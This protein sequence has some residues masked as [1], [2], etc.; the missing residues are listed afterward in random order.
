MWPPCP[1]QGAHRSALPSRNASRRGE[2]E[3]ERAARLTPVCI[4]QGYDYCLNILY[5]HIAMLGLPTDRCAYT[6]RPGPAEGMQTSAMGTCT[7]RSHPACPQKGHQSHHPC[8]T[9][10]PLTRTRGLNCCG[11]LSSS[12]PCGSLHVRCRFPATC[13]SKTRRKDPSCRPSPLLGLWKIIKR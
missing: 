9:R 3:L 13:W 5:L 6:G 1:H 12:I 11:G 7:S 10:P 4:L 2:T 8:S